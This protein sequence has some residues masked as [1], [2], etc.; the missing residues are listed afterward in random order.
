MKKRISYWFLL[1]F[2]AL[3]LNNA[4]AQTTNVINGQF[5]LTFKFGTTWNEVL[6]IIDPLH[7]GAADIIEDAPTFGQFLVQFRDFPTGEIECKKLKELLSAACP[8]CPHPKS[9]SS[10]GVQGGGM[11]RKT[12]VSFGQGKPPIK[13]GVINQGVNSGT[14]KIPKDP[15]VGDCEVLIAFLDSGVDID[16]FINQGISGTSSERFNRTQLETVLGGDPYDQNGHGTHVIG[17]AAEMVKNFPNI[18]ILSIKTQDKK[19]EGTVWGAIKGLEIAV[20]KGS[21]T[22]NMSLSYKEDCMNMKKDVSGELSAIAI[23]IKQNSDPIDPVDPLETES[24]QPLEIAMRIAGETY[25]VLCI[26]A[27]GNNAHDLNANDFYVYPSMFRLHNQINVAALD[28]NNGLVTPGEWGTN[29]GSDFVD[30]GAQ[31]VNVHSTLLDGTE[32]LRNGTSAAAPQVTAVAGIIAAMSCRREGDYISI[33]D[34]ILNTAGYNYLPL[35]TKGYLQPGEAY[36]C[37]FKGFG[38]DGNHDTTLEDRDANNSN[39]KNGRYSIHPNPFH[40]VL[41]LN[42]DVNRDSEMTQCALYNMTGQMVKKEVYEGKVNTTWNVEN[43]PNGVYLLKIQHNGT[44][45]VRKLVKQ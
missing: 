10:S 42:I 32:G 5:I 41:S 45:E 7:N 38:G 9:T 39:D 16:H 21:K 25:G 40:E 31:G 14:G 6:D 29:Y 20:L 2:F 22:V 17:I 28:E 12:Y 3:S 4:Q 37:G 35:S 19:G 30:I 1:C 33:K 36:M 13:P 24:E 43:L 23:S 15:K 18:G 44:Q 8:K 11:N 34:C 27:A 26:T